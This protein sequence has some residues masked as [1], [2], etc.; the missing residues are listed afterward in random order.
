MASSP[1]AGGPHETEHDELLCV[2]NSRRAAIQNSLTPCWGNRP[3]V[4]AMFDELRE[5]NAASPALQ[6]HLRK[7]LAVEL[8]KIDIA[9]FILQDPGPY[10][11]VCEQVTTELRELMYTKDHETEKLAPYLAAYEDTLL[12]HDLQQ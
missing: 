7:M 4:W 10:R 2:L 3:L 5:N 12:V 11:L 9:S 8:G 1:E 6:A